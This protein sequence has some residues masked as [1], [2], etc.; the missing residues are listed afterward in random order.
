MNAVPYFEL[1][2][3]RQNANWY[4]HLKAPNHEIICNSEGY[5]TRAG[6][7]NAINRVKQYAPIAPVLTR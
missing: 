4:F 5:A 1:W 2:Q 3:S 7:E 6:A